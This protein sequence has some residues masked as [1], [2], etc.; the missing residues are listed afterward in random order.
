M[1]RGFTLIELLVVVLIIGILAAIALPQYTK[2]VERSR[3]AEAMQTL[4][5][6]ATAQSIYYMTNNSFAGT[7]SALNAGDITVPD[8]SD[9]SRWVLGSTGEK[10]TDPAFTVADGKVTM[11]MTRKGGMYTGSAISIEVSDSGAIN[12]TVTS[13]DNGFKS[14]VATGGYK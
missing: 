12:K 7:L 13:T 3:A 11:K 6:L 5:D 10:V 14:I 2:A 4:G 9:V 1:N 8:P